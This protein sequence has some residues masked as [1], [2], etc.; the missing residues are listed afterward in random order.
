[1]IGFPGVIEVNRENVAKYSTSRFR[2]IRSAFRNSSRP[3]RRMDCPR[4]ILLGDFDR[5]DNDRAE[6][7]VDHRAAATYPDATIRRRRRRATTRCSRRTACEYA[8]EWQDG[9]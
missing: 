4:R 1:M 8:S 2:P 7:A 5:P 9:T 3:R 6:H